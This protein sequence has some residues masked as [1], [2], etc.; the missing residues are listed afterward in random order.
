AEWEKQEEER[1]T[2]EAEQAMK[3]QEKEKAE[4][5]HTT[6][7]IDNVVL[8]V[9]DQPLTYYKKKDDL[10]SLALALELD[11]DNG[12]VIELQA[13]IE[14]HMQAHPELAQHPRFAGLY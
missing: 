11:D 14:A 2:C 8:Q 3:A 1:V 13:Q 6:T 9:F 12:K 10:C 5:A 7:H 4:C